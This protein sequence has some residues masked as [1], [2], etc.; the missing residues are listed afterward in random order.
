[1]WLIGLVA[2]MFDPALIITSLAVGLLSRRWWHLLAGILLPPLAFWSLNRE[3]LDETFLPVLLLILLLG[4]A[5]S[6]AAYGF[7]RQLTR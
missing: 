4:A 2:I 3:Y 6:S 1:M 7:R 5:Y